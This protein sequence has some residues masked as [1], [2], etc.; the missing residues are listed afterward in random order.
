M[1][2]LLPMVGVPL[3]GCPAHYEGSSAGFRLFDQ[4]ELTVGRGRQSR[5]DAAGGNR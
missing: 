3:R 5:A 1:N 4:A 2:G